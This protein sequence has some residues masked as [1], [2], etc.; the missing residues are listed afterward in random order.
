[1][2]KRLFET[3]ALI[4][5]ARL[6]LKKLNGKKVNPLA[7]RVLLAILSLMA[8]GLHSTLILLFAGTWLLF[9]LAGDVASRFGVDLSLFVPAP[10]E[11]SGREEAAN[12]RE[13]FVGGG[14]G[15][16]FFSSI[17]MGARRC[18]S[19]VTGLFSGFEGKK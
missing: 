9:L 10:V 11:G 12:S 2:V 6:G 8:Y 13:L 19:F 18:K 1:M 17:K 14:E 16:S 5:L 3:L 7:L 4:L 15:V